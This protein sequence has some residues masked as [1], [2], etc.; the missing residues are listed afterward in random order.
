VFILHSIISTLVSSVY[1]ERSIRGYNLPLLTNI[2]KHTRDTILACYAYKVSVD[3]K[4]HTIIDFKSFVSKCSSVNNSPIISKNDS[5]L[6][7]LHLAV[8]CPEKVPN[9]IS[10]CISK[11]SS[12]EI[13]NLVLI[14]KESLIGIDSAINLFNEI[15][16]EM[17]FFDIEQERNNLTKKD[18]S[19]FIRVGLFIAIKS[20]DYESSLRAA[21]YF[22][23]NHSVIMLSLSLIHSA[24]NSDIPADL[25]VF[26][27]NYLM[28]N[29]PD[30][31]AYTD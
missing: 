16:P 1:Q 24:F 15:Y 9:F 23:G 18:F 2:T 19:Y 30:L 22:G 26:S 4:K 21:L 31:I 17:E 11:E 12:V 3:N 29:T 5:L 20:P 6:I 7:Y 25:L 14:C 10:N 13:C 8:K 28:L 27:K